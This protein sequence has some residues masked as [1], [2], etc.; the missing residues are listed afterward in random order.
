MPLLVTGISHHTAPL[1]IREKLAFT[2]DDYAQE[3]SSLCALPGV[4]EAVLVST[5]NRSEIY[6]VTAA[7][8]SDQFQGWLA[9]RSG[10]DEAAAGQYLYCLADEQA[11]NHLFRVACGLDSMILGEPQILGQL[12]DAWSAAREAGGAGK[13]TD[14][15][16][17]RAF[18]ASKLVR[19]ST[20]I[21]DHPVSVAYIAAVLAR[22]IFGDL[23]TKKVLLI[24]AGEMISLCGRHFHQQGV[25]ALLIANRS[26]ERAQSVARPFKAEALALPDIGERIAEADIVITSTASRTPII[27]ESLIRDALRARR[28]NPIFMVDLGVPRDIA[29]EAADLSDVYL[30]SIDDLR[31]VADENLSHRQRAAVAAE[32]A[33]VDARRE[34]M[35][36][37]H[38]QRAAEGLRRLRGQ[39]ERNGL[40]LAKRALNQIRSGGDTAAIV[41]QLANTLTHRIL[42]LP[43]IR[44]RE[45][46]EQQQDDVLKA[47]DWLFEEDDDEAASPEPGADE[48]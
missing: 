27:S 3:V 30:Y 5:C 28:R 42:H 6:G 11:V 15:L 17:Q 16:F 12:K 8:H 31:Q 10:L 26:L 22:R 20:G 9:A 48:K 25:R 37:L 24:G 41:E 35:R 23:T 33:I 32:S 19:S 45:A 38:G 40:E 39:A 29:P 14:R 43:S 13:V 44:L 46:A 1:Q 7:G 18:A 47:A 2:R 36:W 4:S 21:N 34:F